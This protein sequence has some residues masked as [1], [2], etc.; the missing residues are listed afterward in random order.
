[1]MGAGRNNNLRPRPVLTGDRLT[2]T[3]PSGKSM[4]GRFGLPKKWCK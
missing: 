2:L 4:A 3:K 1:M